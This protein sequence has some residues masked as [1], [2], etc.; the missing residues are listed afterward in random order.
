[1]LR[2]SSVSDKR[3]DK[4]FTVK[5][6]LFLFQQELYKIENIHNLVRDLLIVY[7]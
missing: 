3:E 5:L 6:S 7:G 4:V 2:I 1:M